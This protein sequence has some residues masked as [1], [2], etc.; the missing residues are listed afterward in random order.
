ME[1]VQEFY[2][3]GNGSAKAGYATPRQTRRLFPK[4]P[5]EAPRRKS[6]G[7]SRRVWRV[8]QKT[9]MR[10]CYQSSLCGVARGFAGLSVVDG[11]T[12]ET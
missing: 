6:F 1:T 3:L 7:F 11:R 8:W 4:S 10:T 9:G 2:P 5:G 12:V